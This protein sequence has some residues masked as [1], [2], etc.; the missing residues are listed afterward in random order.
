M[1]S[2]KENVFVSVCGAGPVWTQ[3][4][5]QIQMLFVYLH[6]TTCSEMLCV[7]EQHKH[8]RRYTDVF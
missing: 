4:Q 6:R 8:C 2:L 1:D 3:I 7:T 5:I